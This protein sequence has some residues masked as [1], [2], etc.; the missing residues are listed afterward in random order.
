MA[1]IGHAT[2]RTWVAILAGVAIAEVCYRLAVLATDEWAAAVRALVDH[3]RK[4][5]AAAFGLSIPSDLNAER[6]MWRAVNTLVRRP[7]T[8]SESKDVAG[9]L[10]KFSVREAAE[11]TPTA[12]STPPA[13]SRLL[14]DAW[15]AGSAIVIVQPPDSDHEGEV[16]PDEASTAS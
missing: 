9:I 5:V 10:K 8:Y 11:P 12:A 15:R 1:V 6:L 7:Y 4:G 3:G 13:L 2:L 16:A 14:Q